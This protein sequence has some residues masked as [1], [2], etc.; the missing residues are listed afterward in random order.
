MFTV[1]LCF[2]ATSNKILYQENPH[3][4]VIFQLLLQG[5]LLI[6]L[7]LVAQAAQSNLLILLEA[8]EDIR[9]L[10]VLLSFMIPFSYFL[11]A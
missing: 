5:L 9:T 3:L 10:Y 1:M 8:Q 6:K 2:I 4:L 11:V 7:V